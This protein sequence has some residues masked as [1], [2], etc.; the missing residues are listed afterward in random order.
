MASKVTVQD[1]WQPTWSDARLV[2]TLSLLV[3]HQ[4]EKHSDPIDAALATYFASVGALARSGAPAKL[5]QSDSATDTGGALWHHG[6]VYELAV[7]DTPEEVLSHCDVTESEREEIYKM[8]AILSSHSRCVIATAYGIV[9]SAPAA[10]QQLPKKEK[11]AFTGL[12]SLS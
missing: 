12:I 9:R 8:H 6:E 2:H 7:K 1:T 3:S 10:L 11:L 4:K 5:Y